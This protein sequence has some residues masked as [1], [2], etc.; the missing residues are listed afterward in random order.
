MKYTLIS[1]EDNVMDDPHKNIAW[2]HQ[3]NRTLKNVEVNCYS[4]NKNRSQMLTLQRKRTDLTKQKFK[5]IT[6]ELKKH[7]RRNE[8]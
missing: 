7:S 4:M 5:Q 8:R 2:T 6:S 1:G 3:N